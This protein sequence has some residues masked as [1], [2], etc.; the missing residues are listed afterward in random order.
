MFMHPL[1]GAFFLIILK[2]TN[3]DKSAILIS[4]A[5]LS[6]MGVWL[7]LPIPSECNVS[8]AY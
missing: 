1:Q 4:E 6:I 3:K 5:L 8:F 7:L 2:L